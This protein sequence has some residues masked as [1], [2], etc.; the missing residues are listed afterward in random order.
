MFLLN[1]WYVAAWPAELD[2]GHV[3]TRRILDRP[4]L[5]Y[6]TNA[7]KPVAFLDRCPHRLVPLSAGKR[8]GDVIRCGYHGMAFG[9]DGRCVHIPGQEKI[10]ANA[11]ATVFTVV[12]RYGAI[13]I[14]PGTAQPDPDLIPCVPWPDLPGWTP[15]PGYTH[16][17]ADY[18]LLTDNLLDLSHENYIHQ[19]TIGNEEDETIADFPVRVSIVDGRH[20]RAHRNMPDI[21]PPPFFRVLADSDGRIDRWQTALWAP[22]STNITDVGARPVGADIEQTLVSR[23]LH[24]LTPETEVSTHYFWSHN[25]N[26]RLED[27]ELTDRII[28]AHRRTFDED[29]AMLELQQREVKDSA[30]SVPQIALGVDDA[31]LRA[32]RVLSALLRQQINGSEVL[33][34]ETL[35]I[36]DPEAREPIV[37]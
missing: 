16:V 7:G 2:E 33:V 3:L 18:R 8:T 10:P 34:L 11:A 32:R 35:L 17:A 27:A 31:P 36:P 14:W 25:R 22:P 1:C 23:V 20:V 37:G 12:E 15:S 4:I 24:L 9:E 19:G 21:A 28:D 13:W 6:R 30:L 26:F 5:L 29:K